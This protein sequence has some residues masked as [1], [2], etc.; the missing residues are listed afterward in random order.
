MLP[1]FSE[2][3]LGA[4]PSAG[5]W[6]DNRESGSLLGRCQVNS[7]NWLLTAQGPAAGNPE[8]VGPWK[9]HYTHTPGV[10]EGSLEK[11]FPELTA[12]EE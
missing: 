1:T 5:F 3:L 6:G 11:V 12:E 8:A 4:R 10:E 2:C 7:Y 9:K